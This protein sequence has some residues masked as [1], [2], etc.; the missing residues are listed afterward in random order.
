MLTIIYFNHNIVFM[1]EKFIADIMLG[2]L[3]KWLGILG[4]DCLYFNKIPAPALIK[5]ALDENRIILTRNTGLKSNKTPK[6]IFI[7]DDNWQEQLKEIL[8]VL[9]IDPGLFFTRCVKCNEKLTAVQK[10]IVKDFVPDYVFKTSRNFSYCEKCGKYY[11]DGT[12]IEKV[13]ELLNK[14]VAKIP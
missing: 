13:K 5:T 11:W 12:H 2:K 10:E 8:P 1:Q 14:I 9:K 7:K 4:I 3:A 6:T